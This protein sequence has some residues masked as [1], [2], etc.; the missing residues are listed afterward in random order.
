MASVRHIV[1]FLLTTTVCAGERRA[2][3]EHRRQADGV[4]ET[5]LVQ[6]GR[7][8]RQP[9]RRMDGAH[10]EQAIGDRQP[11]AYE[12]EPIASSPREVEL[13]RITSLSTDSKGNVYVADFGTMTVYVFSSDGSLVRR[14][15]RRGGGP[16]EFRSISTVQVVERDSLYVFDA[17]QQR[18]T[19][20]LPHSNA[21]AYSR[22]LRAVGGHYWVKKALGTNLLFSAYRQSFAPSGSP[23][24]DTGRVEVIRTLRPDGSIV[25]NS[26]LVFPASDFL[27]LRAQGR[28]MVGANPFGRRGLFDLTPGG[29]LVYSGTDTIF[30]R[31][32]ARN[33][34]RRRGFR[35][36]APP[37]RLTGADIQREMD[38]KSDPAMQRLVRAAAPSTW[39]PLR[40]L[41]VDDYSR[42]WLGLTGPG[43]SGGPW[44][45]YD[46]LGRQIG[47]ASVPANVDIKA[48]KSGHAYGVAFDELDVPTIV[49]Y[50]IR[51]RR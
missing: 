22:T 47:R 38:A 27:V 10:P 45:V 26:L 17:D 46:T 19:V 28:V 48:I 9:T 7:V 44:V 5:Q 18:L 15:G 42:I 41:V 16:G 14:I 20:F 13:T 24:R 32:V 30:V 12:F 37:V 23:A 36:H 39:P 25:G 11:T 2:D 40:S 34:E 8:G 29:Q 33:G 21:V 43:G 3:A 49:I 6:S 1:L 50:R 35:V 4:S 31:I 51:E